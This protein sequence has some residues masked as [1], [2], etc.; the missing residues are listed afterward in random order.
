[1]HDQKTPDVGLYRL[2]GPS[3]IGKNGHYVTHFHPIIRSCDRYTV[4]TPPSSN[5][6][7]KFYNNI[8]YLL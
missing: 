5:K 4:A 2:Q 6:I 3:L 1:M 7:L 8:Y